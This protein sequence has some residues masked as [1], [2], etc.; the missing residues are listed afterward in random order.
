MGSAAECIGDACRVPGQ[1]VGGDGRP[2]SSQVM[3]NVGGR[4]GQAMNIRG[5]VAGGTGVANKLLPIGGGMERIVAWVINL[6]SSSP[7]WVDGTGTEG[8]REQGGDIARGW[9]RLREEGRWLVVTT[10]LLMLV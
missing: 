10:L 9:A 7:A 1:A 2:T 6:P 5:Q 3:E 4:M 8:E